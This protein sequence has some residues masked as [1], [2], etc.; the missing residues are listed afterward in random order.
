M[1]QDIISKETN[2]KVEFFICATELNFDEITLLL[3]VTPTSI[4]S[5]NTFMIGEFAKDYWNIETDYEDSLDINNQLVKIT[6]VIFDK[7]DI[8]NKICSK[9]NAKCGFNIVVNVENGEFPAIYFETGFIKLA[10][11]INAEI[12]FDPYFYSD[13]E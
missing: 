10:A 3:D 13:C 7:S 11:S 5:K 8:I 9:F 1:Q 6:N 4:R 2:V 12:G